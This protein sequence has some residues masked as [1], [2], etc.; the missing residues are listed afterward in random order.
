MVRVLLYPM[1]F[2]GAKHIKLS[3]EGTEDSMEFCVKYC[4]EFACHMGINI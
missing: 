2:R 4:V 1:E 3:V